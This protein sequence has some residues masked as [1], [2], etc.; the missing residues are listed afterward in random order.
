LSN[1]HTPDTPLTALIIGAGFSG[2]CAAI[3]LQ[4]A[5]DDNFIIAEKTGGISGTWHD[6]AYPGAACDV[7][8]HLYSF[9]FEAN[10]DWSRRFSPSDEIREYA[11]NI[12]GKYN[13]QKHIHGHTE[14]V[15]ALFNEVT[16]LWKVLSKD[17]K[18]Y[19][20]RFL[21]VSVAILGT[22]QMP[23]IAGIDD[24]DGPAFHSAR[25]DHDID[26]TGKRVAM[27]GSAAS[28]VQI[29]PPVANIADKL[30]VLQ[31]TANYVIPRGDRAYTKLEKFLFRYLPGYVK[32]P[33]L[34]LYLYLE[35]VFFKGFKRGSFVNKYMAGMA[36]RFRKKKIKDDTLRAKLTPNYPMGCKRVLLSDD[37]Y[38]ALQKDNVE[39]ITDEIKRITKTGIQMN[40]GQH[41]DADA[42]IYAT[43]FK[44]TTFMPNLELTGIGG[45]T[46]ANWR[47][48]SKAHRGITIAGMPNAFFML[49]PNTG[50]GHSSMILMIEA[51]VKYVMDFIKHTPTG[52]FAS[53][54]PKAVTKY[55]DWLHSKFSATIWATSCSS[56]YKRPD[57]TNPTIWPFPT[58]KYARLMKRVNFEEYEIS[59]VS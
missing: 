39:L 36:K 42:L 46:L 53:P 3:K 2:I 47:K 40:S 59:N 54:K 41:I 31:R 15:S 20:A 55:N 43:G 1:A 17:G 8:S 9:S 34:A 24:F 18:I 26:L 44:A 16:G 27:I 23:D 45:A 51:Q 28:A 7:P 56:W 37:Y 11:E 4:T 21:V 30:Y 12:V 38:D 52:Q 22:P 58:Y 19:H 32:V 25:W 57:G 35:L 33:R 48:D 13:L 6:N 29:T 14:I 5:G 10:P 50:L 49:G